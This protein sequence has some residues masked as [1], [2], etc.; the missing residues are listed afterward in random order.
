[1]NLLCL[2]LALALTLVLGFVSYI[3]LLYLESLRLLR[4]E[5]PSLEYFRESFAEKIGLETENG[6]L[7]FSLIKHVSLPLAGLFYLCALVRPGVPHWQSV[8]EAIVLSF[9]AMLLTTYLVPMF[10]YRRT[11]G[12]WMLRFL[13]VIK[14]MAI[15]AL[16]L[17]ALLRM[18]Q[19]LLDLD[20]D[21]TG[22]I[23]PAD[24]VEHIEALITAG[25]EEGILEE[26]D[27][28]LIHSVVA[29]GDKNVREVM[30]PRPNIVA[31]SADRSLEDL[32]QLVIHEQF[33]RIP[34]YQDT[35]DNI[36]GFVHVR[37]MFELDPEDRQGKPLKD[38]IR[39]IHL[40]PESKPVSDLLREMQ[41]D[42]S[43]V[44]MVVDEYGNTAGLAT[45]ED[46]VEEILGE[47]RD[48]HEPDRDVRQEGD[49]IFLA[50]GSLDVDRLQDLLDFRPEEDTESTTV[51][52][53]VAEWLGHVPQVGEA[54][55]H[56]G[57]RVEVVA[58]NERRVEQ[59][60]ISR[61]GTLSPV[62]VNS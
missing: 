9:I 55:E 17:T 31:I 32:R 21:A 49:H 19:S 1:M 40:V 59:V 45:M 18:F 13:P 6:S 61:V 35:I 2:A 53:L 51:G 24:S 25:A 26:Q 39:P 48:E 7:T 38:L 27:R 57:I 50:P 29:F 46:L 58:G 3:Q 36:I 34:V 56:G 10:L 4:H 14:L 54:V 62:A 47:I 12:V 41:R 52:G 5:V 8:I 20:Q 22:E 28:K 23:A 37:D 44:V 16:P 43:H 33:S 42:H 60:R 15:C 11:K 30:T